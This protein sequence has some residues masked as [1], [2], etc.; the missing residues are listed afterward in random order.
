MS[1]YPR[2]PDAKKLQSGHRGHGQNRFLSVFDVYF[3]C[4]ISDNFA[5]LIQFD[6]LYTSPKHFLRD[7][8]IFPIVY[9]EHIVI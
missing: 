7:F 1:F 5:M 9:R 3:Q 8:Y 2:H 4:L 6:N